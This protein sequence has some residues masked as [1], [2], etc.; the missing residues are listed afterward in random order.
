MK[1]SLND[2]VRDRSKGLC[3]YCLLARAYAP[4]PHQV[5]HIIAVKHRGSTTASNLALAC[6]ACNKHKSCNLSGIDPESGTIVRLFH[7]RRLKWSTHFRWEG[8][9]LVGRTAIGRATVEVLEINLSHRVEFRRALIDEGHFP[10][11]IK[12]SS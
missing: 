4:L 7:P 8:P 12:E 1:A 6:F 10:P 5:D 3:E 2:L 11:K 9:I